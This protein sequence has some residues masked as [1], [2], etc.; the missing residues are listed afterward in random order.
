MKPE[1][2]DGMAGAGKAARHRWRA[3]C[4]IDLDARLPVLRSQLL[5][6]RA[7][8]SRSQ[9]VRPAGPAACRDGGGDIDVFAIT[10]T[11][12]NNGADTGTVL[13]MELVVHSDPAGP[14]KTFYSAY[15]GEHPRAAEAASKSFAPSASA[16]TSLPLR[17]ADVGH[18]PL[19][20]SSPFPDYR[21]PGG[22]CRS[23]AAHANRTA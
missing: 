2:D 6:E 4:R 13:A 18:C 12:S 19:I 3:V 7:A 14:R 16:R 21:G 1:L 20:V 17:P 11:I 5:H 22:H 23:G 9:S 15:M 10:V 8:A